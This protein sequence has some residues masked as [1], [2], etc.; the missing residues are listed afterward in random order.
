MILFIKRSFLIAFLLSSFLAAA[1]P[2]NDSLDK[3][4]DY[5][6]YYGGVGEKEL[7]E[8]AGYD[9][10]IIDPQAMGGDAR[11]KIAELKKRGCLVIGYL[12]YMEVA[13][14]HRYRARVPEKWFLKVDGKWWTPWGNNYA[15]DLTEPKCRKLLMELTKSEVADY[16]C[17]GVFMDTLA[18]IE[19]PKLP[20]AMRQAQLKGLE[21]L[22]KELRTAYPKF[23][24]VGNWTIQATLPVM[25]K[26]ADIICWENFQPRF[27]E[28][29]N[30]A[31]VFVTEVRKNL[32]ELQKKHHFKVYALWASPNYYELRDDQK[33]MAALA[34]SFGYLA[35]SCIDDYH[36]PLTKKKQTDNNNQ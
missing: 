29:G 3:A 19:H 26:Y 1:A 34:G 13:E 8:L 10:V 5:V 35:Y 16:G 24:F 25:A 2:G 14:W 21:A 31:Y 30:E 36:A 9:V 11:R 22:M 32:D 20:E 28:P 17:D 7:E 6:L 27:F 12:S 15:V 33:K 4:R 18:D 23:I